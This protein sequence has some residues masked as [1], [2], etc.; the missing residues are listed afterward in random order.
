MP[1]EKYQLPR[2]ASWTE[3]ILDETGIIFVS[4]IW[5]IFSPIVL[6]FLGTTAAYNEVIVG[7]LLML[8]P[9]WHIIRRYRDHFV[10]LLTGLLGVWLVVSAVMFDIPSKAVVNQIFVGVVV[11]G[12]TAR[13]AYVAYFRTNS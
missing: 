1:S 3:E 5:L 13:I 2:R 10:L 9:A 7:G 8:L 12:L 11:I 4:G 6:G